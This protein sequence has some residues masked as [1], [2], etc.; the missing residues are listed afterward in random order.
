MAKEPSPAEKKKELDQ[1]IKEA[2]EVEDIAR[3][4]LAQPRPVCNLVKSMKTATR[5]PLRSNAFAV[6]Q[7]ALQVAEQ[8]CDEDLTARQNAVN[9]AVS[10]TRALEKEAERYK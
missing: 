1:A 2:K 7:K 4:N 9:A 3:K 6:L 8:K 10:L 5:V